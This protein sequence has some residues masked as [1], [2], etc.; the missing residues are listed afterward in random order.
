[1][2]NAM[3]VEG[4][5]MQKQLWSKLIIMLVMLIGFLIVFTMMRGLVMERKSTQRE[6][7]QEIGRNHVR[8]SNNQ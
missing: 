3:N 5:P 1:M 6:V 7:I 4:Y 8:H 2:L